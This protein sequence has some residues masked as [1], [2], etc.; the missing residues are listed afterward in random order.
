MI[1]AAS[2]L[3]HG[4]PHFLVTPIHNPRDGSATDKNRAAPRIACALAW[5]GHTRVPVRT[6]EGVKRRTFTAMFKK[7]SGRGRLCANGVGKAGDS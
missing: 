4:V 7:L 6:G 5:R 1:G 2:K 3:S